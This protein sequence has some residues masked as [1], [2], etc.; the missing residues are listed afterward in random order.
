MTLPSN[1]VIRLPL[2]SDNSDY[3]Q[4]IE[5]SNSVNESWIKPQTQWSDRAPYS[6]VMFMSCWGVTVVAPQVFNGQSWEIN[7]FAK[8]T[9]VLGCVKALIINIH[10]ERPSLFKC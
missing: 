1:T 4:L 7:C 3:T 10:L 8:S 9:Y 2:F 6:T 5:Y